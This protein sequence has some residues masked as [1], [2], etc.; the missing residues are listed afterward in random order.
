MHRIIFLLL[1]LLI[2]LSGNG[3]ISIRQVWQ[4]DSTKIT[5]LTY[6]LP[7]NFLDVNVSYVKRTYLPGPFSAYAA[8]L[9]GI[10]TAITAEQTEYQLGRMEF[11]VG[12]E[13]DP[14]KRFAVNWAGDA[15]KP[16]PFQLKLGQSGMPE[17]FGYQTG[18]V[19][20][21]SGA[22]RERDNG[23]VKAE[24]E[25]QKA[26][27]VPLTILPAGTN[28]RPVKDTIYM[29]G[30]P[31]DSVSQEQIRVVNRVVQ[32]DSR[33]KAMAA[34]EKY[35]RIRESR[36]S[37]L[38]GEQEVA[39]SYETIQYMVEGLLGL[40]REY[41]EQFTGKV[42]TEEMN[43]IHRYLPADTMAIEPVPLFRFSARH[44]VCG[45]SEEE[46][47][48][49]SIIGRIVENVNSAAGVVVIPEN[50]FIYRPA[51]P[52]DFII[53]RED[54]VLAHKSVMLGQAGK[55]ATLFLKPGM[56][57]Y[58]DPDTGGLRCVKIK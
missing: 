10:T 49:V 7:R 34:V 24:R 4:G 3:Q 12:T 33:E 57:I 23:H 53:I 18:E 30:T 39:Y 51:V 48:V 58:F 54:D 28:I 11:V 2:S 42:V 31:G 35:F 25:K 32:K 1:L 9:L 41:L 44:G 47:E 13:P 19:I 20:Q 15:K 38:S 21:P 26:E 45:L 16:I 36:L 50:S 29:L 37:L 27:E 22:L 14:S 5:G 6:H 40:E 8:E 17:Y 55:E 46:G 52:V 56:E 43:H